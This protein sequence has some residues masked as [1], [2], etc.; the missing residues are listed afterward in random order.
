M[1]FVFL[2]VI[3]YER[4]HN[5]SRKVFILPAGKYSC[6]CISPEPCK[7]LS[8]ELPGHH[9]PSGVRCPDLIPSMAGNWASR[10]S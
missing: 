8:G 10:R 9:Q 3:Y 7:D 4:M 6:C 1:S 2:L 5:Q